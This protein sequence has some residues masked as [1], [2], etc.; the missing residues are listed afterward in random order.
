MVAETKFMIQAAVRLSS[1]FDVEAISVQDLCDIA[2]IH[3]ECSKVLWHVAIELQC[4]AV[5][6]RVQVVTF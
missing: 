1:F 5:A 6:Q 3:R 4:M 2:E